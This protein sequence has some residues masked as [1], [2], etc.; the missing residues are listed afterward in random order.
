MKQV[1]IVRNDLHMS[2]GKIAAQVAHGGREFLRRS[3]SIGSDRFNERC[4]YV[5]LEGSEASWLFGDRTTIVL[6]ADSEQHLLR[7]EQI[8]NQAGVPAYLIRDLGRT[9]VEPNTATVLS[10]GPSPK[11]I[12]D[13]ITR[14][15]KLLK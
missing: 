15:L 7:L 1:I 3:I 6:Q 11:E 10:L 13:P 14:G 9:E 12:M 2:V 4:F 8:A 5:D